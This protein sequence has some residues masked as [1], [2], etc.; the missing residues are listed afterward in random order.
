MPGYLHSDE[1]LFVFF[2]LA[3]VIMAGSLLKVVER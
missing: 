3:L 2:F 1:I